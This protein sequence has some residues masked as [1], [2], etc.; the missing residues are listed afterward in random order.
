ML[1]PA[2]PATLL[3]SGVGVASGLAQE[4]LDLAA[5]VEEGDD[6]HSF[7]ADEIDQTVISD[8]DLTAV[9]VPRFGHFAGAFGE[10]GQVASLLID[11]FRE[12]GRNVSVVAADEL[13]DLL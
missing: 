5:T 7:G 2:K 3:L 9:G 8:E 10:V 4:P 1:I 13:D 11:S 12:S 6:G